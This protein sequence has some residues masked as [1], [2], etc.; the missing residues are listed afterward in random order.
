[1]NQEHLP[2]SF[3]LLRQFLDY[4]GAEAGL[5]SGTLQAYES[6]LTD[7][8]R[9]LDLRR[10]EDLADLKPVRLVDYVE[11]CHRRALAP[12]TVWRRMV[13]VRMFYRFLVLDGY[14]E[15][16]VTQG[17]NTPRL[18]KRV[19]GF[20]SVADVERLL[21]AP[22]GEGPLALRDRAALEMLY[23]TGARA[24]ELCGLDVGSVNFEYTF[25]RC[26]GKRGKERLVPVGSRALQALRRYIGDGR[27][28]LL[29]DGSGAAL[30]LTRRGTRLSR[31]SLLALVRKYGRAAGLGAEVHPHMLRHSFATHLL[32][33]GA[34]LRAVQVMLGHADIS[35]TEIYSHVGRDR[36]L[37]V[38]KH[39]H[40]RA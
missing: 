33:G 2:D 40:P 8:L 23:A 37:R 35:T 4:C 34:D 15:S 13:A 19:P 25:A 27:G 39:Y 18:W 5:T 21:A 38:H 12:N 7:F 30:F 24:S 36:L 3:S 31:H 29:R 17:F 1:M 10:G 9:T 28:A 16:D 26:L 20:L 6:D 32:A 22:E 14:V 11:S